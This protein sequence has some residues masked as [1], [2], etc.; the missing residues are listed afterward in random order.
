VVANAQPRSLKQ[1]DEMQSL[2][3]PK[4]SKTGQNFDQFEILDSAVE[5][6]G[7]SLDKTEFINVNPENNCDE[8]LSAYLKDMGRYALLNKEEE[9]LLGKQAQQ[10]SELAKRRLAQANLRLVVSIAKR[11]VGRGLSLGD[12]IQEGNVGL[13]KAVD[14]VRPRARFPI[15]D[16]CHLVD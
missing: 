11:F 4:Y 5:I 1:G 9:Q 3:K 12:L 2:S 14:K 6:N 16:L 10:G 7:D 13:L 15:L 8:A